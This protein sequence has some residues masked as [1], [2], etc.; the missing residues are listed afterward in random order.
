MHRGHLQEDCSEGSETG[1]EGGENDPAKREDEIVTEER[2][3]VEQVEE[4]DETE[5][6]VEV[7][8]CKENRRSENAGDETSPSPKQKIEREEGGH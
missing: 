4:V 7:E 6:G 1:Q 2:K 8:V 5:H 3:S